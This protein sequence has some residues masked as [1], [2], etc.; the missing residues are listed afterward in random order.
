MAVPPEEHERTLA[1]AEVALQQ[2]RALGQSASP[3]NFEIWYHYATGYNPPLNQTI[4]EALAHG[5]FVIATDEVGSAYDLLDDAS[6]T[7]VPANDL[8]R[9]P[10][11]MIHAARRTVSRGTHGTAIGLLGVVAIAPAKAQA[12][13]L[14]AGTMIL[15]PYLRDE[16]PGPKPRAS[17][18]AYLPTGGKHA[19]LEKNA[20]NNYG[21]LLALKY[22]LEIA[23]KLNIKKIF[24][25]S[26]LVI[27]YWSQWKMK[28][29]E[30]PHATVELAGEVAAM[31]EAFEKNGGHIVRISGDDNPADL[32]FH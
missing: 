20:T 3:R 29:K 22:A 10:E 7:M 2:I 9:L 18:Q 25:D 26:K 5:L 15:F 31:R 21:E 12:A 27:E 13:N 6:G 4:N 16:K 1:F 24:G 11:A 32:G 14:R 19:V 30:L 8:Q 17:L 28:R 23:E